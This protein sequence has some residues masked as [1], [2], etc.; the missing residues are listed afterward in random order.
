MPMIDV[1]LTP[2]EIRLMPY[3]GEGGGLRDDSI[4]AY[5]AVAKAAQRK[6]LGVLKEPCHKK[7]H[8]GS[9][10]AFKRGYRVMRLRCPK[11]MA[12][13]EEALK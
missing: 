12:E 7:A 5:E 6:L 4:P 8:H 11:C 3:C 1:L 9:G 2:E 10:E 13:I